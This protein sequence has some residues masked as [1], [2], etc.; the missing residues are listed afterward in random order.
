MGICT[1]FLGSKERLSCG[2]RKVWLGSEDAKQTDC[3][4]A[5]RKHQPFYVCVII[6]FEF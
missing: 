2:E 5:M 6:T 4:M 1:L 3:S